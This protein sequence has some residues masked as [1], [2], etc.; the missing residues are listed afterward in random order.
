[1]AVGC[2]G[3]KGAILTSPDGVVWT[4]QVSG[5]MNPLTDVVWGNGRFVAVGG[6]SSTPLV[7]T[8]TDGIIWSPGI[9]LP[10]NAP[11]LMTVTF[12]NGLFVADNGTAADGMNWTALPESFGRLAPFG[13]G[14]GQGV[15]V[16]VGWWAGGSYNAIRYSTNGTNWIQGQGADVGEE[17]GFFGVTWANGQFVAVGFLKTATSPNGQQ[18]TQRRVSDTANFTL[19]DVAFGDEMF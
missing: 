2:T 10:A 6:A 19:R 3:N 9:F 14:Y 8:S 13:I 18:W 4:S 7:V 5:A 17:Q 1:V 12:G 16:T 11:G 15:F